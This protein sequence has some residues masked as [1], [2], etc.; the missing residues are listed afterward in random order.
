M[1]ESSVKLFN[2]NSS[3]L[4]RGYG[5]CRLILVYWNFLSRIKKTVNLI[6]SENKLGNS[7]NLIIGKSIFYCNVSISI[8][9]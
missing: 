5:H 4:H 1:K 9:N 7:M 2:L 8:R 3:I 6:E